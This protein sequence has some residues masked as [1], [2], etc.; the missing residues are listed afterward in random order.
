MSRNFE[1]L[2]NLGR[3]R[4]IFSTEAEETDPIAVPMPMPEPVPYEPANAVPAVEVRP[5]QPEMEADQKNELNKVVQGVFLT[6]GGEAPRAVVVASTEPGNGS[7]WVCA[8]IAEILASHVAGPV[9]VVDANLRSPRLHE[10]FRVQNHHGLSNALRESASVR[11]FVCQVGRPN[12]WLLSC[13]SDPAEWSSL[14]G[15]ERMSMR[16][17]ELRREFR[18]VLIDGPALSA[19]N[20]SI[21]LGRS[22]EGVILVLKANTSRR[23]VA[24]K[25]VQELQGAK[26]RVLGAVL[27]HRTFPIPDAL[28]KKL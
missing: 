1:L 5:S 4:D 19:A 25:A 16:I 24:R 15:S 9:C 26:V 21:G 2:Q 14:V 18:Y 28:Y 13:G 3:E 23:E 22:A 27:N 20:D 17:A 10:E 12:L 11:G 7:S 8:R 6:P